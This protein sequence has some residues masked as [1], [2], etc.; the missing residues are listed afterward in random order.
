M[1]AQTALWCASGVL[2]A[3]FVA[4]GIRVARRPLGAID[5]FGASLRGRHLRLALVFTRSG[6]SRGVT[7]MCVLAVAVYAIARL[8]LAIPVVLIVSQIVSQTIVELIK[9]RYRRIRPEYWLDR[10]EAGHSY[11]SGHATTAAVFFCAWA[12]VAA[13]SA[14]PL[15]AKIPVCAALVAWAGGVSWSRLALGAHYL[16]DVAGGTFFGFAWLCALAA[17]LQVAGHAVL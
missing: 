7:M 6:R 16:S 12:A 2:F 14:L 9:M 10:L 17:G 3:L 13:G 15:A 4:L 8:P 11:P 1:S 5:A